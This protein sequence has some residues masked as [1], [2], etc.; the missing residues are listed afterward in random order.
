MRR[1]PP[2]L[3]PI[4]VR[5]EGL[6]CLVVGG[7]RVAARKVASLLVCGAEV[8]VIA[9]QVC[10][11]IE[12]LPVTVVRRSYQHGDVAGFRLVITATGRG[13][14]DREVFE[15]SEAAGLMVN[16]A[17]NIEACRFFL[18]SLLRRGPVT[19]AVST[20]GTSPYLA[21]WLRRRIAQVVGAEFAAVAAL[22]GEARGALKA[23]GR[24][25]ESADWESLLNDEFA[26]IVAEGRLEEA[27]ERVETW[28][29]RALAS[30]SRSDNCD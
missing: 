28:V 11:E 8:T 14:V 27:R 26:A 19:V 2:P 17:D 9:P 29:V 24:T 10:E 30:P 20:A 15:D 3:Y 12:S 22:L 5:L 4:I 21:T 13:E 18:P 25:T 23:A 1:P 6:A 16:A 7:G